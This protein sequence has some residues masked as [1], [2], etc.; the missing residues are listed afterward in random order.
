MGAK[1]GFA[2][3]GSSSQIMTERTTTSGPS[4][5]TQVPKHQTLQ[6]QLLGA[7]NKWDSQL[8]VRHLHC[9]MAR[10]VPAAI[11]LE[12]LPGL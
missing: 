3:L 10:E 8:Q 12:M 9:T 5:G 6:H 11:Q 1:Q 2:K 4:K 7:K